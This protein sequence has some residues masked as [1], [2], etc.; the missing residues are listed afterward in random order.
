MDR[1]KLR[2]ELAHQAVGFLGGILILSLTASVPEAKG[3][4]AS[5]DR[6]ADLLPARHSGPKA[7]GQFESGVF[8]KAEIVAERV[9]D[10]LSTV[11]T[12][13]Q[14]LDC[15]IASCTHGFSPYFMAKTSPMRRIW[16]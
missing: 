7:A 10:G 1:F 3:E 14:L 6:S 12:S 4:D 16:V 11:V 5:G 8:V 9:E 15:N 2:G 13:E